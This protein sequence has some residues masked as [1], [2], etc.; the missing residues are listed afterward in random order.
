MVNWVKI[1]QSWIFRPILKGLEFISCCGEQA[2]VVT[3]EGSRINTSELTAIFRGEKPFSFEEKETFEE[4]IADLSKREVI[5]LSETQPI[6]P[7]PEKDNVN[8][9]RLWKIRSRLVGPNTPVP[10]VYW[11]DPSLSSFSGLRAYLFNAQYTIG[12]IGSQYPTDWSTGI[13]DELELAELKSITEAL[14]RHASGIIPIPELI[15]TS[16]KKLNRDVINPNRIVAYSE[17]QYQSIP[18]LAKFTSHRE[19]FWKEVLSFSEGKKKYLPIDCLYYPVPEE[20]G[21][22]YYHTLANSSGVAAGFSFEESLLRGVYEICERDAFMVVWLNRL[23]M[24]KIP[25]NLLPARHQEI[26]TTL[27]ELGY[28]VHLVDL[29]LDNVPVVLAIVV[30]PER[31]PALVLGM[32]ANLNIL[33]AVEKALQEILQQLWWAFRRDFKVRVL[34]NPRKVSDVRDHA[35]LYASEKYLRHANFLWSGEFR[36]LKTRIIL[37]SISSWKQELIQV[38]DV[39]EQAGSQVIVADLTPSYFRQAGVWVVRAIVLGLVPVSFGYGLEPLGMPRIKAL[40]SHL[41]LESNRWSRDK[42]FTHPYA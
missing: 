16:A 17:K 13:S 30:N 35:A 18:W 24:P 1:N 12:G 7:S 31:I 14:E 32:S 3:L 28:A 10:K 21:L 9:K 26:T 27:K 38:C 19:Y 42:P 33:L 5:T 11:F 34:K 20:L 4:L 6:K 39:L 41:G 37:S 8:L 23:S 2:I 15:R 40:P 36:D 22:E 25:I 29:T